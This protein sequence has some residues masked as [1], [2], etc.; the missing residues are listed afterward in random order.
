MKQKIFAA[1]LLISCVWAAGA[2]AQSRCRV[3]D[4]TGTPL[5][6]RSAPDGGVV[7]TLPNGVLVAIRENAVDPN[8]KQW[9]N[10]S[11]YSDGAPLGWVFRDFIAC[12]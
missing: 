10:I 7:G 6:I 2:A 8:G 4:P 3:M 12:F 9:A 1:T 5:N 11:Q